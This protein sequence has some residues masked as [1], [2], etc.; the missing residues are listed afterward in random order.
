MR[1]DELIREGRDTDALRLFARTYYDNGKIGH[2]R[3]MLMVR[4]ADEN[5]RLTSQLAAAIKD[6][7][8]LCTKHYEYA[9]DYDAL[10]DICSEYCTHHDAKGC[11]EPSLENSSACVGFMWR[12]IK[13]EDKS[14]GQ[15]R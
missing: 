6:I 13:E 7:N 4:M 3:M 8:N 5:D 1:F 15:H 10:A 12:G 11:F 9:D 14:D 2:T